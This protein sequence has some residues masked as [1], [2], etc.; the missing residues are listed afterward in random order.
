[1]LKMYFGKGLQRGDKIWLSQLNILYFLPTTRKRMQI[2][3][4]ALD[5]YI[6]DNNKDMGIYTFNRI[7]TNDI[8]YLQYL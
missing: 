8:N 2:G 5:I 4:E 1:M 7:S 3:D 6:F